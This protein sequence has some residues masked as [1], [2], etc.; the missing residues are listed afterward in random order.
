MLITTIVG[1]ALLC[2]AAVLLVPRF[3]GPEAAVRT[4]F[5]ALADRDATKARELLADGSAIGQPGPVAG[6]DERADLSLLTNGTLRSPGYTPPRNLSIER[7]NWTGASATVHAS[8]DFGGPRITVTLPLMNERGM[9]GLPSWRITDGLLELR[10]DSAA[11]GQL[12]V[13]G[14]SLPMATARSLVAFPGAYRVTLPE[15]PLY[16]AE[17]VIAFAG[18]AIA[19]PSPVQVRE[20]VRQDVEQQAR[21]HVDGCARRNQLAPSGCPFVASSSVPVKIVAWSIVRY[22]ELSFTLGTG[23]EVSVTSPAQGVAAATVVRS[24]GAGT[25]WQETVTFDIRGT[26]DVVDGKAVLSIAR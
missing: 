4:Y 19:S 16:R 3:I 12:I 8:Y 13:A 25:S 10:L 5:D 2:T 22:P 26:V 21:A 6:V 20:S 17:P 24:S 15:H 18:G 14:S 11:T 23:G 7:A 9:R 1:L